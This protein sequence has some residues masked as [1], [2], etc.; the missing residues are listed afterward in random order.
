MRATPLAWLPSPRVKPDEVSKPAA[1]VAIPAVAIPLT[2][3][4]R[5]ALLGGTGATVWFTGLPGS[6]KTT[7]SAAVERSLLGDGYLAHR[8]DGDEVRRHLCRDLG[9]DREA[10]AENVRRV[11]N[12]ARVLAD[13]GVVVL[14]AL[15]S[16]YAADRRRARDEHTEIG[17]P[18]LEVF[19]DTPVAV[20]QERDPKGLYARA[21]A[22]DL[23]RL[24]GVDDPYE[25]PRDPDLRV[26]PQPLH[27]SVKDVLDALSR[28][29]A[30]TPAARRRALS[31]G[32]SA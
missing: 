8:L 29:G 28:A 11:A 21:E 14:V 30:L 2:R 9:F 27:Q 17:L 23:H 31:A 1:A 7:L 6:G 16:P 10:R 13:A 18:F 19:V 5:H 25:S 24:T 26:V 22:G 15:I 20:C 12:V 32:A 4:E 3:D